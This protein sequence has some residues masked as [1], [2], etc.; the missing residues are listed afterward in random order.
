MLNRESS[1][2]NLKW[3]KEPAHYSSTSENTPKATA[4]GKGKKRKNDQGTF[5]G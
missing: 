2:K 1:Q 4:T 5:G 3:K